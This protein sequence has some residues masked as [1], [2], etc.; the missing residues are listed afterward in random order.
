MKSKIAKRWSE[1]TPKFWKSVQKIGIFVGSLGL[2]MVAPPIG[3]AAA[4]S[5]LIT[6]G[7]VIGVLS[8]LTVENSDN[9]ENQDK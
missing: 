1:P 9:L 6:A 2:I 4:G 5:Y 3:L 8:Q 7:S